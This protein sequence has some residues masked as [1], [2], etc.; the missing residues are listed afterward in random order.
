MPYRNDEEARTRRR[1]LATPLSDRTDRLADG[2]AVRATVPRASHRDWSAPVDR[3]DPVEWM[4]RTNADRLEHY[5]P[6]RVSRMMASPFTFLRGSAELMAIDLVG[7]P[8]SGFVT[9]A[10]GDSHLSNFGMY[11]SPER[12]L[13]MDVNDFDMVH[14]G[15]WEWDVKRLAASIVVASRGNGLSPAD[16]RGSVIS[17]IRQYAES[18]ATISSRG[19]LDF[20]TQTMT[21][22]LLQTVLHRT[23]MAKEIE[24]AQKKARNRTQASTIPKFTER[25]VH[26]AYQIIDAPP[27]LVRLDSPQAPAGL[28]T[29]E[30]IVEALDGYVANLPYEWQRVLHAYSVMD[31]AY[32]VSGVGSAGLRTYL[33]LL[34]GNGHDD[35]IFLQL[36]EAA[37]SV[38]AGRSPFH[39]SRH[40][41]EGQRV[42]SYQ[43]RSQNVSDPLLG[44]T[45]LGGRDFYVRQMRDMKGAIP[46]EDLDEDEMPIYARICG[47]LLARAHS[48]TA[49]PA[50]ISGYLGKG[51]EIDEAMADFADA[52]AHQ[53]EA[54]WSAIRTAALAGELPYSTD[55]LSLLESKDKKKKR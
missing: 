9:S 34:T 10:I 38:L 29:R 24:L 11:A 52:Y 5:R 48:R 26:G 18:M 8:N 46:I 55:E 35:A 32:R 36:K 37:P 17:L 14:P 19:V 15:P 7:T 6:I 3:P 44:W 40:T 42:V 43:K 12:Q 47:A 41:H 13:V 23:S 1:S 27:H 50:L 51:A 4:N 53:T 28:A 49:D 21:V 20:H 54:D 30:E 31:V 16:A 25:L 45:S 33:A 22:E 39:T 2:K